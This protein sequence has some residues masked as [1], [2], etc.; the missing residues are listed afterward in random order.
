[1]SAESLSEVCHGE[2]EVPGVPTPPIAEV[3]SASSI[4]DKGPTE[5][6]AYGS[7]GDSGWLHVGVKASLPPT[8]P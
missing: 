5:L 8:H 1:V 7:G 3:E 6:G 4:P 2:G